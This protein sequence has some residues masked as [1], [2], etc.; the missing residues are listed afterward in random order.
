MADIISQ[1][2][3][4]QVK[5][6]KRL[7]EG[8]R[9]AL[10]PM[11]SIILWEQ[12]W[13]PATIVGVLSFLYFFIWLMDSNFLTTFAI[14]GIF[15]NF[16][17]FIV[18]IICTSLYGPSAWTGQKEKIF[19]DIC[20]AIVRDYNKI[21]NHVQLFF[22]FRETSPILYYIIS[23]C[24]LCTLGWVSSAI[25]NVLLLYILSIGLLLWPG[26]QHRGIFNMVLS[27][28]NMAPKPKYLKPE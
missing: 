8:W 25:N 19:E 28:V 12:Q 20:K 4:Q 10:L 11:R 23:M 3:E 7:L 27:M 6:L 13:Y 15:L 1:D 2:Q 17:D 21:L 16:L 24:L 5:K 14:V 9:M 22:S 26:I 18:P